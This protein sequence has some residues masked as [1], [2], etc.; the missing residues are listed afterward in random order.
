[1][2]PENPS[3]DMYVEP[4]EESTEIMRGESTRKE[5]EGTV[6]N[7]SMIESIPALHEV[8]DIKN[9]EEQDESEQPGPEQEHME[10]VTG[11]REPGQIVDVMVEELDEMSVKR[12]ISVNLE[13]RSPT[14]EEVSSS[15]RVESTPYHFIFSQDFR[16]MVPTVF[17]SRIAV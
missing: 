11:E 8:L 16:G 3:M 6:N 9:E 5:P 10:G 15:T 14:Q 17:T 12:E 4:M 7:N 1:V 13:P 2:K